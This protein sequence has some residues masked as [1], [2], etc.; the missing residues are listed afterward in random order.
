VNPPVIFL[1]PTLSLDEARRVLD[2][3]YRPPVAQGDLYRATLAEPSVI[4]VIDGYFERV[5]A[6]W[7]KEILWA[8]SRRIPV[9]GA[10]SMGALRA[11]ELHHFGMV[12]VGWVFRAFA[13]GILEGD[14]EVAV[15]HTPLDPGGACRTLSV[16]MVDL[17]RTVWHAVDARVLTAGAANGLLSG[18]KALQFSERQYSSMIEAARQ[19]GVPSAE[20]DAFADWFPAGQVRQKRDDALEA[21]RKMASGDVASPLLPEGFVFENTDGWRAAKASIDRS[22]L[23]PFLELERDTS[24][25]LWPATDGLRTLLSREADRLEIPIDWEAV[26]DDIVAFRIA[27]GFQDAA[28]FRIWLG[29][30]GLTES[31]LLEAAAE[32][33]RL[34]TAEAHIRDSA[35]NDCR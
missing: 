3:D 16:A 20:L 32:R 9:W 21:L 33:Q 4:C 11:A 5:P 10:A 17:R 22:Y 2:A 23:W 24:S 31:G 27:Q 1:G 30:R 14:D 29:D 26:A 34:I 19:A 12:G 28:S 13:D 25:A 15:A 6:V 18:A 7:H 35:P 8:L